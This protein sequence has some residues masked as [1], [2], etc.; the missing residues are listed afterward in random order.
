MINKKFYTNKNLKPIKILLKDA[1]D[2]SGIFEYLKTSKIFKYNIDNFV[3][4]CFPE[5]HNGLA[6]N[7]SLRLLNVVN[8]FELNEE[9]KNKIL[10]DAGFISNKVFEQPAFAKKYD[11]IIFSLLLDSLTV[12]YKHKKTGKSLAWVCYPDFTNKES[13]KLYNSELN[14][15]LKFQEYNEDKI[16][17]PYTYEKLEKYSEDFEYLGYIKPE[18]L[19]ECIDY[20][21]KK[22]HKTTKWIFIVGSDLKPPERLCNVWSQLAYENRKAFNPK[23]LKHFKHYKNIVLIFH[24]VNILKTFILN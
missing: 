12:L 20:L 13:W 18:Q 9:Q 4:N 7:H 3:V 21:I 11:V 19:I 2:I 14:N 23:L 16:E 1:C 8:S 17:N 6:I 22:I 24:L 10:N 15:I 5:N